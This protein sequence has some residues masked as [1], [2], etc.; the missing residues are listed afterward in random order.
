MILEARV[1]KIWFGLK[2][3]VVV[4]AYCAKTRQPVAEPHIGCGHC[5]ET[6]K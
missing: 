1:E 6:G 2:Q 5:H 3:Q 4:T